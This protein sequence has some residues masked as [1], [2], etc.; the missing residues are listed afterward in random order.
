MTDLRKAAEM[1]LEALK[2]VVWT[3]NPPVNKA[4][5]ELQEAL[6]K[7]DKVNQMLVE[8]L[9]MA[10]AQLSGA[11]MNLSV[12]KKKVHAALSKVKEQA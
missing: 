9:V 3:N 7:P 1:A 6:A 2:L 12:L 11:N 10:D 8:A 4:I 5:A